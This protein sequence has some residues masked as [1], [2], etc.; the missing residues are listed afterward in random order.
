MSL[1]IELENSESTRF[2]TLCAI[3]LLIVVAIATLASWRLYPLFIDTYYHM[4]VIEGFAQAG[5]ITTRAFWEM[6]PGGRVHIYPP[7]LHVIGYFFYLIGISPRIYITLV[8]ATFYAGCM[9]TT[10]IWLRK[11]IGQ[12][13]ALFALI[14]LCGPY[15]FFWTQA[16]FN[17][18]AGVLVLA[19]LALLAL[20]SEHFLT[21]GV[22]NFVAIT[23]HP[24]GLFLP[25][26]LVIN[27]LLR[28]KKIW[29][30]LLAASV[31]VVLY[32]PWLAHIWA[33][34]ALLPDNRTGS[35]I[36]F[37]GP[38]GGANLGLF[39]RTLG[40]AFYSLANHTARPGLRLGRGISGIRRGFAHGLWRQVPGIQYPLAA[41]VSG[42][43]RLGR[44]SAMARTPRSTANWSVPICNRSGGYR[45][46]GVSG[47]RNIAA[48]GSRRAGWT[49]R[50]A[51]G[52]RAR[53]E[54][55][56]TSTNWRFS[57][58]TAAL[59]QLFGGNSGDGPGGGMGPGPG[60]Q[61]RQA[62]MGPQMG[63]RP[64]MG[65]PRDAGPVQEMGLGEMRDRYKR[66]RRDLKWDQ[67]GKWA[68]GDRWGRDDK[69]DAAQAAD[70]AC[71]E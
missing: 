69:W 40:P 22:L 26:A 48:Q 44:I 66:R 29:A 59:P 25:P 21:C 53:G 6:A 10:W 41:G 61:G 58:Q 2:Y 17:A 33:N 3:G 31:P 14:L 45:T 30:G 8:S 28:R 54:P 16:S 56:A 12:R 20:E 35:E 24:M 32:G 50:T 34:R 52:R 67:D 18:V 11:I 60:L 7:S 63:N 23:M 1:Q 46:G 71:P 55:G 5:G 47:D 4:G 62:N 39:L 13:S 19:P 70:Q 27:T 9:L 49:R 43:V 42:R 37:G 38:G 68:R 65:P 57:I 64:Q 36:T 15:A 51:Y